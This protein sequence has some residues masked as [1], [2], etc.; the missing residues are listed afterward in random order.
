MGCITGT[1]LSNNTESFE[2]LE[3]SL[4]TLAPREKDGSLMYILDAMRN[5]MYGTS[6]AAELD[7]KSIFF[8]FNST[9]NGEFQT[10]FVNTATRL[11]QAEGMQ[12]LLAEIEASGVM[13]KGEKAIDF[14]STQ[15]LEFTQKGGTMAIR[16]KYS[17]KVASVDHLFRFMDQFYSNL[18]GNISLFTSEVVGSSMLNLSYTSE[19]AGSTIKGLSTSMHR[20]LDEGMVLNLFSIL[21]PSELATVVSKGEGHQ[22]ILLEKYGQAG[23]FGTV[24]NEIL[25]YLKARYVAIDDEFQKLP[26]DHPKAPIMDRELDDLYAIIEDNGVLHREWSNL[27]NAN[28][29]YLAKLG[30]NLN[31]ILHLDEAQDDTAEINS[32][33]ALGI[34]AA[35]EVNPAS[36]LSKEVKVILKT[37][38]DVL[39]WNEVEGN[40]LFRSTRVGTPK[41]KSFGTVINALSIS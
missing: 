9:H 3:K 20:Y 39:G 33:D 28:I 8:D 23:S 24:Y 38:P 4:L 40:Y 18:E 5:F 10:L 2:K 11:L 22:D 6:Y 13:S 12:D 14:L 32:R 36:R 7:A 1:G 41:G 21:S 34:T 29:S 15:F 16:S 35:N 26:A 30:L 31:D 17:T 25:E 37:L 19:G 27:V